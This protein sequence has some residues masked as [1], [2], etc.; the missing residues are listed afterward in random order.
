MRILPS[1]FI[2]DLAKEQ[3]NIIKHGIDF[4]TAARAFIDPHRKIYTDNKHS[5][6]EP[7]L[8]A[9][10]IG[11]REKNIMIKKISKDSDRPIGKMKRVNDFLP[12]PNQLVMPESTVKVTLSLTKSSLAF[13]KKQARK[14][15]TKY[16]KMIREVV[17]RYAKQF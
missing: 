14:Y 17:D 9:Q 15:K 11:A 8:L 13:F 16:Q 6:F 1:S 4:A 5:Q 3:L 10:G 7:R 12:P 2:W